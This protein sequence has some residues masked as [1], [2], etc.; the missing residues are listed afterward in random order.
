MSS[1]YRGAWTERRMKK[2]H[3]TNREWEL[4]IWRPDTL[5][6]WQWCTWWWWLLQGELSND[7]PQWMDHDLGQNAPPPP[8]PLSDTMICNTL[9]REMSGVWCPTENCFFT[10]LG[11]GA[12]LNPLNQICHLTFLVSGRSQLQQSFQ[13]GE[14]SAHNLSGRSD[15]IPPH[16]NAHFSRFIM[17]SACLKGFR[18]ALLCCCLLLLYII[19]SSKYTTAYALWGLSTQCNNR[20][21]CSKKRPNGSIQ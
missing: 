5:F 10:F 3:N 13:F 14:A 11:G 18:T 21:R 19:M 4:P 8:I 2:Q 12:L 17:R 20:S 7:V 1:H 9:K 15:S 16:P 6:F